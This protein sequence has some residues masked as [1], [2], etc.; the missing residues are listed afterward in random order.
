MS[1]WTTAPEMRSL[2]VRIF[3]EIICDLFDQPVI[4]NLY[5]PHCVGRMVA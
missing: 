2:P 1:G 4:S 3:D 5:R